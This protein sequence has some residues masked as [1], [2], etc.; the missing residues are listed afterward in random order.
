MWLMDKTPHGAGSPGSAI[1]ETIGRPTTIKAASKP[2][3]FI[4]NRVKVCGE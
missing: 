2:N 4:F 1:A 3:G